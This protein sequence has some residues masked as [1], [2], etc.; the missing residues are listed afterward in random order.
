MKKFFKPLTIAF[1]FLIVLDFVLLG[2][3]LKRK[4]SK[5]GSCLVLEEKYCGK[6]EL[7]YKGNKPVFVGF[8]LPEN[9]PIFSP[10]SGDFSNTPTFFAQKGEDYITYP[11]IS[12]TGDDTVIDK[13]GK[14]RPARIFS[15]VYFDS[16]FGPES[17]HLRVEEKVMVGFVS[18]REIE[19]YGNYNL[20][21]GFYKFNIEKRMFSLDEEYL[22]KLFSL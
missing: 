6:G 19:A 8:K 2:I 1:C 22:R 4:S 7:V 9:T 18:E 5:P 20:L 17:R 10:Y 13:D 3:F 21:I 14:D 15:A 16:K 11:G 12:I